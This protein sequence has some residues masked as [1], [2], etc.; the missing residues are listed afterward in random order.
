MSS[1]TTGKFL[2]DYYNNDK[3]LQLYNTLAEEEC[4]YYQD[5]DFIP[6]YF[7]ETLCVFIDNTFFNS[8]NISEYL[9]VLKFLSLYNNYIYND[10]FDFYKN[11][12][13]YEEVDYMANCIQSFL[14]SDF[15]ELPLE[16]ISCILI[17]ERNYIKFLTI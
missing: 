14:N 4:N 3:E 9:D 5:N 11:Q 7:P 1:Y 13:S 12:I 6:Y 10:N 15:G 2:D 16:L 8:H 17:G